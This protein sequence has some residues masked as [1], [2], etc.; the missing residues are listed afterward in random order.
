MNIS[1]GLS[2]INI[3]A[4]SGASQAS[5]VYLWPDYDRGSIEKIQPVTKETP[6]RIFY[7]RATDEDTQR[8][9]SAVREQKENSYSPTGS[10]SDKNSLVRP[11]MLFD[12]KV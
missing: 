8:I 3:P 11:G 4:T 5:K 7:T 2:V 9:I 10:Y 12:A 6:D 1:G